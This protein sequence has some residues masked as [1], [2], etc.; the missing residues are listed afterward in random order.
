[1]IANDLRSFQGTLDE[2]EQRLRKLLRKSAGNL[3][4]G[5][6]KDCHFTDPSQARCLKHLPPEARTGPLIAACQPARC[7]NASIHH[8]HLPGW[9]AVIAHTD[10]LVNDPVISR[11]VP[12]HDEN[13]SRSSETNTPA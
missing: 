13:A 9:R 8:D 12:Q 10:E 11:K 5:V 6:L 7:A 3:H 4:F 2:R 1:V